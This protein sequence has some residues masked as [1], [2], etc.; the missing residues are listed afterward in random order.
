MDSNEVKKLKKE[1][2]E[3]RRVH[4]LMD[5]K[6]DRLERKFGVDVPERFLEPEEQK[7]G[8]PEESSIPLDLRPDEAAGEE[9]AFK[10][11]TPSREVV[12]TASPRKDKDLEFRI[13][14]T[15]FNR[16]GVVAVIIG[17]AFFIKYSF[18][19]N[20]IGPTGRVILGII[21]GLAMLGTGEK[22]RER[23]F[24]YAQGL[25]G[26][27][28]LA[29][30]VSVYAAYQF[31]GL[32]SS[33]LAFSFLGLVMVSTVFLSVRHNS[34]PI[35]ILGIIGGYL[36]P[37]LIGGPGDPALWPLIT[38]LIM[39]T[40][41][42]LGVSLYKR[43]PLF[44]YL[45]FILNQGFIAILL[46]ENFTW[47]SPP[48][49]FAPLFTYAVFTFVLYLGVA[50]LY[51]LLNKKKSRGWD[52]ALN[53]LNAFL[54][55]MWS[56]FMLTDSVFQD[57]L[58]FYTLMIAVL[59]LFL[60][61]SAY[62]LYAEDRGQVYILF[63][64]SFVC[65]TI[66]I[67]LQLTGIFMGLAWLAQ[68]V[69]LVFAA[70][71]LK[72]ERM[73]YAG[74]AVLVLGMLSAY[75]YFETLWFEQRFLLNDATLMLFASLAALA[76]IAWFLEDM[77][78]LMLSNLKLSSLL[79]GIFLLQVLVGLNMQNSHYFRLFHREFFF[80]PEQL[81]LSA[82]WLIYAVVLF[83]LGL[84]K[85]NSSLRYGALGLLGIIIFK[86]FLVDLA[87]LDTM[88]KILLFIG[89]GLSLLAVSFIYQKKREFLKGEEE[90]V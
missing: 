86:A 44:Q 17:L 80:S 20:W 63:L 13:G 54:F 61:R 85:N 18:D 28:S 46:A 47:Y 14:G 26:G 32:L 62:R 79:K 45:S 49:N 1:V 53:L 51:N 2:T 74:L 88:F 81:S 27:G 55:L 15:W 33:P 56:I 57:Y 29:L 69:G 38:Y 84:R 76:L 7:S 65:L 36:I 34:L 25:M 11:G 73:A 23:Y 37:V 3:L 40:A 35:G 87:S 9:A 41:G 66:A 83:T 22:L 30:F 77:E 31:Y 60:G 64:V 6:L 58:G 8:K 75:R 19:N 68:A 42:V 70:S 67:P 48:S 39:L 24:S 59:Y 12:Y 90:K 71:R 43:W 16:I 89:L 72:Q 50:T 5:R 21:A 52:L 78:G 4:R 82:L 10:G